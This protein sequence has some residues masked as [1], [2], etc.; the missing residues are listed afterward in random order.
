MGLQHHSCGCSARGPNS[1]DEPF[2]TGAAAE[3]VTL[4]EAWEILE[5]ALVLFERKGFGRRELLPRSLHHSGLRHSHALRIHGRV[6]D[7]VGARTLGSSAE[8][9]QV[10]S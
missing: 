10:S 8:E 1:I 9:V 5:R 7:A 2:L 4:D 6:G 3:T